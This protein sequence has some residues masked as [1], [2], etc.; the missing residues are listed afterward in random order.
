MAKKEIKSFSELYDEPLNKENLKKIIEKQK[1]L[2]INEFKKAR[3]GISQTCLLMEA[4]YGLDISEEGII[5]RKRL[6]EINE[7]LREF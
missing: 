2:N 7:F 1:K 3:L 4:G 5:K 6:F